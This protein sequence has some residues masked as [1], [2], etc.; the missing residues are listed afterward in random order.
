MI[1]AI[2][3]TYLTITFGSG[4][5]LGKKNQSDSEGYFMA[6]RNLGTF[7]LFMTLI[8][9]NFSAFFFLGFAGEGY[10]IGYAYYAMTAFGTAF[11][12]ITFYLIG[13]RAWTLGR[14]KGYITSVEMIGGETNHEPTRLIFLLTLLL[15]MI[16]YVSIQPIG[17]GLILEELTDGAIS[18]GAG[19][20]GMTLFIILH[21]IF[22]G[23]K[24]V[25]MLDVKNGILMLT[26]MTAALFV[27]TWQMG[28]IAEVN[29][30]L[31]AQDPELFASYGKGEFF[32]PKKWL[33]F[34]IIFGCG[35]VIFPQLFT[36]FMISKTPQDLQRSTLLYTII[37]IFL[38]LLP[39]MIG[40]M[41]NLNFPGL[42]G[43]EPDKILSKMLLMHTP[44]W[45][46]AMILTGALAAFIS[47]MDSVLLALATITSRDF[48]KPILKIE[49]EKGQILGAKLSIV[50]FALISLSIA[51]SKP[52]T[53]FALGKLTLSAM[54][55][56]F[57]AV[58][59]IL[60]FNVIRPIFYFLSILLGQ[61]VLVSI[62][63]F[64]LELPFFT[65]WLPVA[66]AF[67][68]A[69]LVLGVGFIFRKNE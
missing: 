56:L 57:P 13:Q 30:K 25:I 49:D 53:I 65:G 14:Q 51:F 20:I 38:F 33:S 67:A 37:P 62:S 7:S 22:G 24:G 54:A 27:I 42:E 39:V 41:G 47:T 12:A 64:N 36:R 34:M 66:P 61:L 55:V 40:M 1:Y 8:A 31:L 52:T 35:V 45:F 58:L 43:K 9:T 23:M 4:F 10:K 15:F 2:L 18:Y 59:M 26:F 5:F 28:G 69:W 46:A 16:P 17:A 48:L 63:F 68:T 32:H 6:N 50:F 60:R 44:K 29:E 19:V 21:I 11:A 3:I